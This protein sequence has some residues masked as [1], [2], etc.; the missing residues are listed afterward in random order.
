MEVIDRSDPYSVYEYDQSSSFDDVIDDVPVSVA[1]SKFARDLNEGFDDGPTIDVNA[2]TQIDDDINQ[3]DQSQVHRKLK[4]INKLN[5]AGLRPA[6]QMAPVVTTSGAVVE[7]FLV[8]SDVTHPKYGNGQIVALDGRSSKRSARV[9]FE[10]GE[11][12]TFFLVSSP[13]ALRK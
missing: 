13:L 2:D 12:K 1:R 10:S 11:S 3:D 5:L 4:R 7:H 6:T 8:G 9:R